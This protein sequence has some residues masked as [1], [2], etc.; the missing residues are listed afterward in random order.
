MRIIKR[1][2][3]KEKKVKSKKVRREYTDDEKAKIRERMT[4]IIAKRKAEKKEE[5][6]QELLKK[7]N[8]VQIAKEVKIQLED[9][10]LYLEVGD[11]V[12][13]IPKGT[14]VKEADDEK[15]KDKD[16]DK[17]DKKKKKKD[18]PKFGQEKKESEE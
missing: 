8:V 18:D 9:R 3:D 5:E 6:I 16:K 2:E 12:E 17:D 7:E 13:I 15:D 14:E 4:G 10:D 1:A 11:I